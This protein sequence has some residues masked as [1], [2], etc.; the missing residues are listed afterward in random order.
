MTSK[1]STHEI[2]QHASEEDAWIVVNGKVYDVTKFAPEHPGGAESKIDL[3][4]T[5]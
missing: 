2:S 1:V 3:D 4:P 5:L